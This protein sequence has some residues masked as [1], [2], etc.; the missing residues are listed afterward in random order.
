[1]STCDSEGYPRESTEIV[2]FDDVTVNGVVVTVFDYQLQRDGERPTTTWT[3][4]L[5]VAGVPGFMLQPV[6]A[7]GTYRVWV[8]VTQGAQEIVVDAGG[9]ERT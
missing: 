5:D 1:M 4:P 8:K 3:A 2:L 6:T 9:I 7:R